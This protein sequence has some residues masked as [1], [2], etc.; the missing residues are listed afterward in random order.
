MTDAARDEA[1]ARI[2]RNIER[3]G[4]HLYLI[5]GDHL[6][7]YAYTIGLGP[8]VGAELLFAGAPQ[9]SMGDVSAVV[10]C[11]ADQLLQDSTIRSVAVAGLGTFGLECVDE[12]WARNLLLGALDYYGT[13]RV[14]ALQVIPPIDQ[15]TIDVPRMDVPWSATTEPVW[16]WLRDEPVSAPDAATAATHLAALLGAP[17]TEVTR[18]ELDYWEMFAGSGLDVAKEGGLIVPLSTMVGHDRTLGAATELAIGE[19]LWRTDATSPWQP[20]VRRR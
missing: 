7:R 3:H 17:I 4:H 19:G 15:R 20:W 8:Q 18:W 11:L 13:D 2:R 16:Q 9:Y 14:S 10:T 5:T 12:S 1:L 6:P